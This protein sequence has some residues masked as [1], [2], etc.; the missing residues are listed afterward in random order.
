MTK[1]R[2]PFLWIVEL[3]K[4]VRV[5]VRAWTPTE[6]KRTAKRGYPKFKVVHLIPYGASS[7]Y[8]FEQK[9]QVKAKA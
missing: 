2:E 1:R 8:P 4:T 9:E 7:D 3:S 6:A 5:H